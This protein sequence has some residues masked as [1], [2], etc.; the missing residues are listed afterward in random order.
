M[1][2]AF[3]RGFWEGVNPLFLLAHLLFW[4]G[5]LVSL[6]MCRWDAFSWLYPTY[7]RIMGWSLAIQ[8]RFNFSSPWGPKQPAEPQQ[9]A[10]TP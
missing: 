10:G 4:V 3:W 1:S 6:P 9:G 7:N 5:H 8:E 2:K